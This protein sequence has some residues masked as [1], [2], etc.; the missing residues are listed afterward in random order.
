MK[1]HEW[2]VLKSG[3]VAWPKVSTTDEAGSGP[4]RRYYA[5]I[6]VVHA[7]LF[8]PHARR[9]E[10][11]IKITTRLHVVEG[12]D[13]IADELNNLLLRHLRG[14]CLVKPRE[15]SEVVLLNSPAS[16]MT[17]C[18]NG[19]EAD[20]NLTLTVADKFLIGL[21]ATGVQRRENDWPAAFHRQPIEAKA[22]VAF[23]VEIL[24]FQAI[25]LD[26]AAG[27]ALEELE[28]ALRVKPG[29]K[30]MGMRCLESREYA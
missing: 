12:W 19:F 25:G 22:G 8:A 9:S 10:T 18:T 17:D 7:N 27:D 4:A 24:G 26:Y 30:N 11:L 2:H 1:P 21:F 28:L 3:Q 6:D 5:R 14:E 16:P 20:L 29:K 15:L 23:L 13:R